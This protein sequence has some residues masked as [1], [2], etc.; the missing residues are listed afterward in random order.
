MLTAGGENIHNSGVKLFKVTQYL[1]LQSPAVYR[2]AMFC[3]P[4]MHMSCGSPVLRPWANI[5]VVGLQWTHK[6]NE[7]IIYCPVNGCQQ[8]FYPQQLPVDYILI[9]FFPKNSLLELTCALTLTITI[10]GPLHLTL[11]SSR[12]R[13][14][15]V[16]VII[17]FEILRL[18]NYRYMNWVQKLWLSGRV[19]R[20]HWV[21]GEPGT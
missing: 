12:E 2:W 18:D 6:I 13:K 14:V 1:A 15:F 21:A 7:G 10:V 19:Q 5:T 4:D 3:Q 11:E 20:K 9:I 16:C 17:D 8:T